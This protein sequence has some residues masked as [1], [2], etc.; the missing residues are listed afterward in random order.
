[1]IPHGPEHEL[2]GCTWRRDDP[3]LGQPEVVVTSVHE[4]PDLYDVAK[5]AIRVFRRGQPS[6][7]AMRALGDLLVEEWQASPRRP[8]YPTSLPTDLQRVT[9]FVERNLASAMTVRA[10]ANVAGCSESTLTRRFREHLH[11]SPMEWIT[12]RRM[13][14]AIELLGTTNLPVAHVGRQCGVDDPYYFSRLFRRHTGLSPRAWR[15]SQH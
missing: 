10:L 3:G 12:G 13:E 2:A 7:T 11:T 15:R 5:Y 14:R 9:S 1:G 6:V 8:A 4:H